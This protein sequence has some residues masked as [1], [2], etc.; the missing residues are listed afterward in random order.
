M[1]DGIQDLI[2]YLVGASIVGLVVWTWW[3]WAALHDLKLKVAEN[4]VTHE[5]LDE[6]KT[7]IRTVRDVLYRVAL[8]MDVPVFSEPFHR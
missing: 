6:I 1:N 5:S 2:V 4:Y 7:E 3:L 8:K